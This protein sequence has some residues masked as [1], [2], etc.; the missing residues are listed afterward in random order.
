MSTKQFYVIAL[1]FFALSAVLSL[2]AIWLYNTYSSYQEKINANIKE[3][4]L[5]SIDEDYHNRRVELGGPSSFVLTPDKY[6][7]GIKR[8]ATVEY[9]DTIMV[10]EYDPANLYDKNKI[11]QLV[12]NHIIPLKPADLNTTFQKRLE[13]NSIPYIGTMIEYHNINKDTIL[14]SNELN[15]NFTVKL[16]E[17]DLTYID[18]IDSMGIKAYIQIPY[19][20]IF[21]HIAI[22][23]FISILLL[24]GI[25]FCLYKFSKTIFRQWKEQEIKKYYIDSMTH[26]LRKPVTSSLAMLEYVSDGIKKSSYSSADEFVSDSMLALKKLNLSIEKIQEISKGEDG[27]IEFEWKNIP[28]Q[29]FIYELTE[30]Y[31]RNKEKTI[32]FE[33]DIPERILFRTDTYHFS[34]IMDNLIENSIKYSAQTVNIKIT[35]SIQNNRIKIIHKD[36]GWGIPDSEINHIFDKFFRSNSVEKRRKSGVGLGLSYIQLIVRNMKGTIHVSSKENQFTEF[37]MEFPLHENQ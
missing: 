19:L 27:K 1:L 3:C 17:T 30:K 35:A 15:K 8:K 2:Q 34:N 23:L 33:I 32:H 21:K 10:F 28:L 31:R 7:P 13:N 18:L 14:Y 36:D 25:L 5:L 24:I 37:V 4:F 6:E 16:Y 20:F 29:A 22:K 9:E 11:E 26:E 12:L